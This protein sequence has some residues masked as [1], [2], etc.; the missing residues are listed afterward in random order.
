MFLCILLIMMADII[1]GGA[2]ERILPGNCM[3]VS[4]SSFS[5][6]DLESNSTRGAHGQPTSL[7]ID[8]R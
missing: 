7:K 1:F 8:P 2:G 6:V 4:F 5:A 3:L